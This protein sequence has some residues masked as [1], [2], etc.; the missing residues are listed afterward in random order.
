MSAYERLLSLNPE[1]LQPDGFEEAFV[2]II[3]RSGTPPVGAYDYSRCIGSLID[4]GMDFIEAIE[5][6][7]FNTIGA[8]VGLGTPAYVE[9]FEE[10]GGGFAG[11]EEDIHVDPRYQSV[12]IGICCHFGRNGAERVVC[13]DLG[14]TL[15]QIESSGLVL[16]PDSALECWRTS[17]LPCDSTEAPAWLERHKWQK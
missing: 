3:H 17:I 10:D 15:R 1:A 16:D 7:E 13:Y 2:G 8:Y 4:S 11:L 14:E 6:F 12:L 5:F 9:F